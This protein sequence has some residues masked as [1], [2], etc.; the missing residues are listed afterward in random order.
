MVHVRIKREDCT[1]CSTCWETCPE[2]FEENRDD[3]FSQIREEFRSGGGISEGE[4]PES[5][6]GCVE[7]AAA[8]CP[9]QIIS[10]TNE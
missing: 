5:L 1:A 7:E 2:V 3:S 6:K 10:L 4:V 9:V 8:L